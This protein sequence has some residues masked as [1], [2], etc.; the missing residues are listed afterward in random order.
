MKDT[1]KL[2]VSSILVLT[3]IAALEWSGDKVSEKRQA[4][5]VDPAEFAR[6]F[7]EQTE[8]TV[9]PEVEA[10][11][12]KETAE[13]VQRLDESLYSLLEESRFAELREHLLADASV[14]VA[15]KDRALLGE[16][17]SVLGQVSIEEQDLDSAEVFLTEALDV[18]RETGSELGEAQVYMQLGRLHVKGR[19]IARTA[20]YAYDAL[21]VG[22]WQLQQQQY[23]EAEATILKSIEINLSI[24]RFGAAA[25]AYQSL[26]ELYKRLGNQFEF[27][28]SA[29]KA[30]RLFAS[31]GRA[32]QAQSVIDQLS[33][34][35]VSDWRLLSVKD[36]ISMNLQA[37]EEDIGQIRRA[38]D[39]QRLYYYYRNTGELD[40]A[41][42][43]RLLASNSLSNVSKRAM[44]HRQ[45][46]VLAI[47]YNSN[48]SMALANNFLGQAQSTFNRKGLDDLVEQ[49]RQL[50]TA[51]Y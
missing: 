36:E 28:E 11:F 31:S 20:A 49:T 5:E 3:V 38:Q 13:D 6:W 10:A 44:F 17:L 14:A 30:A 41:W 22:R 43:F 4:G 23:P 15:N 29:L 1:R 50:T 7:A 26:A 33:E 51:V 25:S 12:L 27:E 47:L 35:G 16:I 32:Y 18:I 42:H 37:Y 19:E 45:Q 9:D 34:T 8:P 2:I 40:R 46:G 24:N 48:E 21:Q 39:F